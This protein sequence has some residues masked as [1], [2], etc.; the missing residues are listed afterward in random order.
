MNLINFSNWLLEEL[1]PCID[2][3]VSNISIQ[4]KSS[5]FKLHVNSTNSC[6]FASHAIV[7]VIS[8]NMSFIQLG[9]TWINYSMNTDLRQAQKARSL[10]DQAAM[11]D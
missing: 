1:A 10:T 6:T 11:S 4:Q 5:D 2:F 8:R 7:A 9:T 3:D